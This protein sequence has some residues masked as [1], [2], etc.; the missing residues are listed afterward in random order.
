M[1][2]KAF[3]LDR[4][5]VLNRETGY[6]KNWDKIKFYKG[7]FSALR[8]IEEKDYLI[9]II[10]N[11]SIIARKIAKKT[12]IMRL[13]DKLIQ[14]LKNKKIN[15]TEIFLCPHHPEFTGTCRCRKPN[16][17]LILQAIKKYN[18]NKKKKLVCRRQNI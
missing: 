7:T 8:K 2:R 10:T 14:Y 1:K 11:Q 13:H 16:N 6:I 17:H 3:F 9:I 5:G 15:I 12:E 18:I 4:D